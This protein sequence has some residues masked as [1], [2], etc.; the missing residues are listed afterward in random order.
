MNKVEVIK[1]GEQIQI[2]G[3]ELLFFGLPLSLQRKVRSALTSF[4]NFILGEQFYAK[5]QNNSAVP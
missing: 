2:G 4:F 1:E 5:K 3:N